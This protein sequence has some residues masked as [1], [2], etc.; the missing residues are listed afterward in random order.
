MA[1]KQKSGSNKGYRFGGK[2][3]HGHS[4]SAYF[5][6]AELRILRNKARRIKKD[7]ERKAATKAKNNLT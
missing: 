3:K 1:K 7:A 5:A 6:Q 4:R 2:Q